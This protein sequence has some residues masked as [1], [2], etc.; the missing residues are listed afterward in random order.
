MVC[1]VLF[2]C[3]GCPN[4]CGGQG[5]GPWLRWLKWTE[6]VEAEASDTFVADARSGLGMYRANVLKTMFRPR[7]A[8][9][10]HARF[11]SL[12][13]PKTAMCGLR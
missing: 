13:R 9:M 10:A 4:W 12:C 2:S 6:G 5:E 1:G 3:P 8:I 11:E 7:I